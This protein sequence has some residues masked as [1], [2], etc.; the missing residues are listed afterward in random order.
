MRFMISY[1]TASAC[2]CSLAEARLAQSWNLSLRR[3]PA[4]SL[5]DYV[6]K[7]FGM[8]VVI[9][10]VSTLTLCPGFAAVRRWAAG[11]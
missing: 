7:A 11:E 5:S 10:H 2:R 8:E 4:G 3:K 9:T 1:V 6:S